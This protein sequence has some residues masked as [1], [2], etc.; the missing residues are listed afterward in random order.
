MCNDMNLKENN[1][2]SHGT[3]QFFNVVSRQNFNKDESLLKND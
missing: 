1:Y 3:I 2:I